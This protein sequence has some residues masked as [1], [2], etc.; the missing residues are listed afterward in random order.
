MSIWK[1]DG[2]FIC[3]EKQYL[4]VSLIHQFLSEE[5][6]WVP[7]IKLEI[8]KK[9]IEN[10]SICFGV[11]EGDPARGNAKQIGFARAVSDFCRFGWIMDVF[12]LGEFG[13]RGLSKW[14]MEVITEQSD[15][16]DAAKLMLATNDA[17]GLYAQYGFKTIK[18]RDLYMER[19]L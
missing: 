11:Y 1:K 19:K 6:Y 16:K 4:D 8:V 12:I 15:L 2:F 14:L 17:H 9:S 18:N 10:S 3:T 7:G 5:S 13:G